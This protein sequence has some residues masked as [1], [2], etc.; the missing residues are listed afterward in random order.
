MKNKMNFMNTYIRIINKHIANQKIPKDYG[1]GI[2]LHPS[3]IHTIAM[4]GLNPGINCMKLSKKMGVTRGA[5]S[6]IVNRLEKKNLISKY[7]KEDNKKEVYLKLE[8]LGLIAYQNQKTIG[9][10]FYKDLYK[11]V[12]G[13]SQNEIE[14]LENIFKELE[15][16]VDM[17]MNNGGNDD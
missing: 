3:E 14:F 9:D 16:F 1:I 17:R 15:Y 6:Q 13:A 11:K 8:E 5:T 7:K 10:K 4:I 2:L 12:E